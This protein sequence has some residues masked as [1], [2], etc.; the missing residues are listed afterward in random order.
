MVK[1]LADLLT[2]DKAGAYSITYMQV[3]RTNGVV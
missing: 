2:L 3:H 1:S